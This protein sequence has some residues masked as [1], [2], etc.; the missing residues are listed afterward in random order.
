MLLGAAGG[1]MV[2]VAFLTGGIGTG[3]AFGKAFARAGSL[4]YSVGFEREA[5]YVGAY[6]ATRAG[7]DVA[8]SEEFWRAMSLVHPDSIRFAKTHPTTPERFIQMQKV[9]TEIANRQRR[10][11]PLEPDLKVFQAQPDPP[12]AREGNF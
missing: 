9:A 3:G 2:D 4:A 7:Y 5:D 1:V 12:P 6:Y 8:G 11:E 10:H